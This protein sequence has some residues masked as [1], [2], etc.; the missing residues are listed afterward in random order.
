MSAPHMYAQILTAL[1]LQPDQ[2]FL[3]IGSGSGYLSCLVACLIGEG[4]VSHGVEINPLLIEHSKASCRSWLE[5]IHRIHEEGVAKI[6]KVAREGI[7]FVQGNGFNI[8]V[9]T[10]KSVC[11]Y[12]RIYIGAGCPERHIKY[13]VQ[14]LANDGVLIAPILETG[15]L[16]RIRKFIGSC[17]EKRSISTVY[18]APLLSIPNFRLNQLLTPG[19]IGIY[20]SGSDD[21]TSREASDV[22]MLDLQ[23]ARNSI[24]SVDNDIYGSRSSQVMSQNQFI[25]VKL[26]PL[27]WRPILSRHRQFP[28]NFR[29]ATFVIYLAARFPRKHDNLVCRLDFH[30]WAHV[31]SFASRDWFVKEQSPVESL[32]AEVGIERKLRIKAEKLLRE[33]ENERDVLRKLIV[34]LQR[35]NPNFNGIVS[36]TFLIAHLRD[37]DNNEDWQDHQDHQDTE[38]H[39]DA[40][41]IIGDEDD[42][43]IDMNH[44]DEVEPLGNADS[45]DEDEMESLHE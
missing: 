17:Y 27:L 21:D 11:L 31:L 9:N 36:S 2:A 10:A 19:P 7:E 20:D 41:S 16:I 5:N 3:N 29:R 25:L 42:A 18:Y 33:A 28:S 26:P 13:F 39:V 35:G 22:E 15:D 4:G 14:L 30:L 44:E 37:N 12:D 6:P 40:A 43:S 8:D 23:S 38:M 1:D 24:A 45:E 34:R 32:R